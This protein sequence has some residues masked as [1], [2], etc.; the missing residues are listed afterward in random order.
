MVYIHTAFYG[1]QASKRILLTSVP[2][3]DI[4]DGIIQGTDRDS[5]PEGAT[6]SWGLSNN[7]S[8]CCHVRSAEQLLHLISSCSSS[9]PPELVQHPIPFTGSTNNDSPT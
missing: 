6:V 7:G 8:S 3:P 5:R 9:P 4:C 1:Q 2:M